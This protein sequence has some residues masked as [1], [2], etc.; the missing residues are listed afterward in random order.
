M[1]LVKLMTSIL[2][3]LFELSL[4][5]TRILFYFILFIYVFFFSNADIVQDVFKISKS[6]PNDEDLSGAAFS[7]AQLQGAYRLNVS[8]LASGNVQLSDRISF[9]SVR[10]L[11]GI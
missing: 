7:L 10:G 9:P 2:F 3:N 8:Q 4:G 6:F 5:I 11:N 1:L